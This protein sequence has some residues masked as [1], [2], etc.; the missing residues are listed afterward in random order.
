MRSAVWP[1]PAVRDQ[2][3]QIFL[4]LFRKHIFGKETKEPAKRNHVTNAVISGIILEMAQGT[5]QSC[6]NGVILADLRQSQRC[7]NA[8]NNPGG[9]ALALSLIA[10]VVGNLVELLK[11]SGMSRS[12]E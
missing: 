6:A 3:L 2:R 9:L 1:G 5:R 8:K 10:T 4:E 11:I 7:C 12:M